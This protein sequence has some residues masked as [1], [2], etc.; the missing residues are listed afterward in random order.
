MNSIQLLPLGNADSGI[1]DSLRAPLRETFRTTVE[2]A[3]SPLDLGRFYDEKRVQYNSSEIIREL[4]ALHAKE[5][6][7]FARADKVIAVLPQD[8]FIPILTYVF[9]EAQ[10][11]GTVAVASYHRLQS[12][13]YGLPPNRDLLIERFAKEA[14]HEVGHLHGLVHCHSQQCVMRTST[15]VEDIDLKSGRLCLECEAVLFPPLRRRGR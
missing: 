6:T 4:A 7:R 3:E 9:G 12:E 14:V 8:L 10:L 15:Y 1:V 13:R 2:V 11:G 5:G